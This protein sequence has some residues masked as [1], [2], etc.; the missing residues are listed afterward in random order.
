ML[1]EETNTYYHQYLDIL[2]EGWFSTWCNCSG[3]V[4]IFGNYCAHGA[5]TDNLKDYWLTQEEFYMAFYGNIMKHNKFLK[6]LWCL[7]FC[8]NKKGP[9]KTQTIIT[10]HGKIRTIFDKLNDS[11]AKYYS[12]TEHV[13]ADEMIMLLYHVMYWVQSTS[14]IADPKGSPKKIRYNLSLLYPRFG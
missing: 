6:I 12:P 13:A 3:N 14:V 4:F 2:D 8:D 7:H 11:Y 9:D 10:K 5:Q 1:V